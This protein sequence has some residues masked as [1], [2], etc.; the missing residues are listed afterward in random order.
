M[1]I[2]IFAMTHLTNGT[3]VTDLD[4]SD[5][6]AALTAQGYTIRHVETWHRVTDH[7][8]VVWDAP[9]ISVAELPY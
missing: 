6:N 9:E 5:E 4:A 1:Q 7:T 3:V 8:C 2:G